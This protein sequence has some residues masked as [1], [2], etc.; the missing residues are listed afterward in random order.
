MSAIRAYI[1][2]PLNAACFLAG[3]IALGTINC[4]QGFHAE[5]Q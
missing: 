4:P 2:R 5:Y 3:A 1:V